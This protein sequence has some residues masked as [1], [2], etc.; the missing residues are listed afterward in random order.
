MSE[1]NNENNEHTNISGF[2]EMAKNTWVARENK[3][4]NIRAILM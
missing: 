4:Y 3:Q 2:L 1:I